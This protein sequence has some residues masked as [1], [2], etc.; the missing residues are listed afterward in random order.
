MSPQSV[1]GL[2]QRVF[3]RGPTLANGL[4]QCPRLRVSSIPAKVSAEARHFE[5]QIRQVLLDGVPNEE[6]IDAPITMDEAISESDDP[7]PDSTGGI[8]RRA[9][10][11]ARSLADD[12][13]I[14]NDRVLDHPFPKER[15][16]S[17]S[18]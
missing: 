13:E 4:Y 6:E 16:A 17:V 1:N 9:R 2:K 14:T 3:T 5:F 8:A 7:L 10:Q 12:F 11:S 18:P 15:L